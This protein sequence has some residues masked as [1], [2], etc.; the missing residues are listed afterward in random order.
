MMTK[1]KKIAIVGAGV[2]GMA[3]GILATKQ[4]HQVSLFE[5]GSNVSYLGAG[6]TL[7]P[8]AMVRHAE[9]GAGRK[10]QARRGYTVHDAPV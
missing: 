9:D 8:N 4:G 10:N 6:V 7:W 5:R 2:A 1:P 3:L